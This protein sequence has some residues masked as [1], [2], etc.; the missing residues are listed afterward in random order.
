[1]CQH[2]PPIFFII[3]NG[4]LIGAWSFIESKLISSK[5]AEA[6]GDA[7]EVI[8]VINVAVDWS[9]ESIILDVGGFFFI[10]F[11]DQPRWLAHRI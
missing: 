6:R 8:N 5:E 10:I 3:R 2:P 9:A 11:G 7:L 1:M 4:P